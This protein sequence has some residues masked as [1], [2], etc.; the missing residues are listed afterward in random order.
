MSPNVDRVREFK[1]YFH[2]ADLWEGRPSIHVAVGRE[3]D[4]DAKIWLD[5]LLVQRQGRLTKQ[6]LTAALNIIKD[7]RRQ[8][9]EVWNEYRRRAGLG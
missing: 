7:R 6:Q 3:T 8:Y 1:F 5:D 4:H 2:A 9:L